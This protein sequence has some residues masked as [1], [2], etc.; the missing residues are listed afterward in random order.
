MP[1]G[2]IRL[3]FVLVVVGGGLAI[4]LLTAPGGWYASLAKPPFNPPSWV[5]GPVWTLLYV[6]IAIAG[7]RTYEREAGRWPM[8]LWMIQLCLNFLWTPVFFAAHRI[9]LALVILIL[10]LVSILAFIVQSW[11]R[12]PIRAWLFVPYAVWVGFASLLNGWIWALN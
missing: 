6:M 3:L 2:L 7:W 1:R 8:K 11:R 5:F 10:L 12:D 4:G 9:G